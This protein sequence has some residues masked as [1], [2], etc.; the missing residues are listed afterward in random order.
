MFRFGF[1]SCSDDDSGDGGTG[2]TTQTALLGK[3]NLSDND[4]YGSVEFTGD[5]KYVVTKFVDSANGLST[6]STSE[7]KYAIIIFGDYTVNNNQSAE[8]NY[9]INLQQFGTITI[10]ISNPGNIDVIINDGENTYNYTAD[11]AEA[12]ELTDKTKLLCRTWNLDKGIEDGGE[13]WIGEGETITFTN[14]GT[15]AIYSPNLDE[16]DIAMGMSNYDCGSW[17]WVDS[18]T[19]KVEYTSYYWTEVEMLPVGSEREPSVDY[20]TEQATTTLKLLKL[21]EKELVWYGRDNERPE[22]SA[23]IYLSR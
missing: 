9:V 18:E 11:K 4:N 5:N 23:T 7:T 10:N 15:Y 13:E 20:S 3:Y 8:N 2:G 12:V 6:K 1:Y 17:S 19:I 22:C 16:E 14:N 21:I